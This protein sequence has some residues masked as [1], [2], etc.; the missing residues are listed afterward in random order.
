LEFKAFEG[1]NPLEKAGPRS[2]PQQAVVV[3][4]IFTIN[5]AVPLLTG[6]IDIFIGAFIFIGFEKY[7]Y[8]I[9]IGTRTKKYNR[10][11]RT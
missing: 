2:A 7:N 6:N 5:S 4:S 3:C 11:R 9:F 1:R 10:N 8:D